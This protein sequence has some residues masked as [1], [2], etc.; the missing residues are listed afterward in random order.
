MFRDFDIQLREA[1]SAEIDNF[2]RN[3]YRA[4][5]LLPRDRGYIW[6]Q[7]QSAHDFKVQRNWKERVQTLG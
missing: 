7:E 2:Q 1:Y 5:L 6:D 4:D 3:I